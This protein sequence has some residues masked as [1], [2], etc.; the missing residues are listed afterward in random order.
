MAGPRGAIKVGTG[1]ISIEPHL[2]REALGRMRATL[3]ATMGHYGR[4]FG[5]SL[6]TGLSRG[7]SGLAHD[8]TAEAKKMNRALTG[9]AKQGNKEREGVHKAAAKRYVRVEE[10]LTRSHGAQ[11]AVRARQALEASERQTRG[12]SADSKR[13]LHAYQRR[14]EDMARADSLLETRQRQAAEERARRMLRAYRDDVR[15][16]RRAQQD[17]QRSLDDTARREREAQRE[18]D[19]YMRSYYAA[20]RENERR[21]RAVTAETARL[22]R[23]VLA[24]LA[25][26]RKA[27]L[28]EELATAQLQA[29]TLRNSVQGYR[30][31]LQQ[32]SHSTA[33]PLG[34]VQTSLKRHADTVHTLGQNAVEAGAL[35]TRNL[36]G[37]LTLVSG[38]LTQIGVKN[39]D[40]RIMGQMGMHA[41][42]VSQPASARE[43]ERLQKYAIDTPF[44]IDLMHE[45]QMKMVRGMVARER[46]HDSKDPKVR[47]EAADR[48]ASRTSDVIEAVLDSMAR[49]GNLSESQQ[50]RSLYAIDKIM[51]LD[52]APTKNFKQFIDATGIPAQEMA[53]LLNFKNADKMYKVMGT[54]AA[55]G[56]G[57]TG[58]QVLDALLENWQGSGSQ[59]GSKG[60]GRE[61][62]TAT[63]TGRI[64]QMKE[65]ASYE[66]GQLFATKDPATGEIRYTGLG[67]KIMGTRDAET[68]VYEGGLLNDV[69][70]IAKAGL[71]HAKEVLGEFFDV[72]GTFTGWIKSTTNY[73]NEHPALQELVLKVIKI[74]AVATPFLVGF[75]LLSK[76]FGKLGKIMAP[77][78]GVARG[79]VSGFKGAGRVG[80]QLSAGVRG[81][82]TERGF[83]GSWKDRRTE[84]RGGDSRSLAQRGLDRLRGRDSRSEDVRLNV[85]QAEQSLR[86]LEE[87]IRAL[88]QELRSVN[89]VSID[90]A[91]NALG[92]VGGRSLAAAAQDAQ[93]RIR[94]A[95]AGLRDLDGRTTGNARG[96]VESLGKKATSTEGRI[97]AASSAMTALNKRPLKA[98]RQEFD[99]TTPKAKEVRRAIQEGV[100]RMTT[101][102]GKPLKALR[103]RFKGGGASLYSAVDAVADKLGT[104]NNRMDTLSGKRVTSTTTSVNNLK[105]A[106]KGASDEASSLKGHVGEVNVLT[107]LGG[108][109]GKGKHRKPSRHALGGVLPGYAPGVDSVPALLSPGEAILRPEVA[110]RL[111]EG[112]INAWNAAAARGRLSRFAQGGVVREQGSGRRW[113]M[114]VLDELVGGLD[115]APV[116]SAFSSGVAMASAGDKIGGVTGGNVRAWGA[117][118]GG[119]TSGRAANSRFGN[120]R[121]FMFDRLPEFLKAAPSGVGNLVG[122]AAGAVAPT[123]GPLFW[124]DVWKGE[125][126]VLE[127]GARFTRDL[128]SP[129]R[130]L[131]MIKD[132]VG[133]VIDLTKQLGSLAKDL[134]TDPKGVLD[135]AI[136][137]LKELFNGVVTNVRSLFDALNELIDNPAEVAGE[138]WDNFH[139]RAREMMPNTK[140]LWTFADGGVVPGYSPGNDRVA[141]LLSPGEAVLRPDAVRALGYKVVLGLNRAAKTGAP[142]ATQAKSEPAV[143]PIPDAK[144]FEE[145]AKRIEKALASMTTSGRTHQRVAGQVWKTVGSRVQQAVDNQITPAQQRWINHLTGPLT[146]GER[147]FRTSSRDNWTSV[148]AQVSTSTT[149]SLASLSR[150]RGGVDETK[151][152]FETSSGRIREVWS[153]AMASVGSSTRSTVAGP[154]N[155]GAVSMMSEMAKLAGT[156]APLSPVHFSTGGVVP[157]YLPGVD[158]VPAVLS[159][160]EGILRPEVVRALGRET[161]LRWNEQARRGGNLYAKGGV[162]PDGG[163]WVRRHKDDPFEGYAEAVGKG[164]DAA[165]NPQLKSVAA[166]FGEAGSLN[167]QSF[168]KAEPWLTRWGKWADEHTG[169]GGGQVVKLA[170]QE[171]KTGDMSGRKYIGGSAYESW[172]AD[173]VSW[174]VDHAGANAAYGG[175]PTDTP[176]N[177]WPAVSTWVSHMG[178]V[179]TSQARPGDLMVFRGFGPGNWGHIDIATGR[180]GKSLETVGGNESRSI[181]RQL[182]YGNRA[183]GALR[184]SGGSPG[185]GEGPVLNPWP[186]SLARFSE[187]VGDYGMSAGGAVNR[188]RPLVERVVGELRGKGGISLSDVGLVLRR[189]AVE[190]G[191]NPNAVNNWDSNARAGTPSKGL[192]QVIKPTFDAY[193]GPYRSLGQFSPLASLYAGLSYAIER[194]GSGWRRALSGTRGYWSGTQSATAGLA[195][196]GEQGP[197]LVNFRGG[198]RVYNAR[199]TEELVAGRRYEIHVHEAKSENTTDA[200]LRALRTAEVMAGF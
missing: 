186:G 183:D 95:A 15:A 177:R 57:I 44:N 94:Q 187:G 189:I 1:F 50:Q 174:I 19:A 122:L 53:Q 10:E 190:S 130:L 173:F 192:L 48:A 142:V 193:A 116:S 62:G 59:P 18:R 141:A 9:Q 34:Q 148:A 16:Y 126:N 135:E 6:S 84:L 133:G 128:L 67:E 102:N 111:G 137:T 191:G 47:Q 3:N 76:L 88:K 96:Q 107:G 54:P 65:R 61:V 87:K 160:G 175:S 188:W 42:G 178:M 110:A 100:E 58:Q 46:G 99:W 163:S 114:N 182:G 23:Q 7:F 159:P 81:A 73:L 197:E 151:R 195:M 83:F 75:G 69:K 200:V 32:L 171:A 64:Q 24:E 198:E 112:T 8:A 5:K 37:P 154:Y 179:P 26:A 138:V 71:P 172:C 85:G 168:E 149:G 167:A 63:I 25:R 30:R 131:D 66:M 185:A 161:I 117:R 74:I 51:D 181:R 143:T 90:P 146:S 101:L 55:K 162:V 184:P 40:M 108:P 22:E 196:V 79:F 17:K 166:K 60:Y 78:L 176:R 125:G 158:T 145:A 103:N 92:G 35:I 134:V 123:A 2:D 93:N 105:R 169:G 136:T 13:A 120:L 115:F 41:A 170:L 91:M 129:S 86:Q 70:D 98:L 45:Y 144:A 180:Q 199:R 68:G 164:W 49:A 97:K 106:L 121:D 89:G 56:G 11:V 109:E 31:E 113:P 14:L 39:A 140:G 132:L 156:K 29:Q 157:G 36:L 20:H 72:L 33:R 153:A 165:I 118:S 194:Y 139:A 4:E 43:M 12:L 28:R 77:M 21:K 52:R 104:V 82:G 147:A 80:R 150:L 119:D 152:L 124:D 127:R 38:A 155:R 27:A